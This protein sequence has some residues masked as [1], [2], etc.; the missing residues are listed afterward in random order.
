MRPIPR[1]RLLHHL[2]E[3]VAAIDLV[4]A[5][6]LQHHELLWLAGAR[7]HGFALLRRAPLQEMAPAA[8]QIREAL[9]VTSA[10]VF[11]FASTAPSDETTLNLKTEGTGFRHAADLL[12]NADK[13]RVPCRAALGGYLSLGS[14][15]NGSVDRR[16]AA[17]Y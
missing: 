2:A 3:G 4:V 16:L 7:I 9:N 12:A 6:A 11:S 17:D 13:D 1:Q 5:E 8:D 15:C 14:G 10:V